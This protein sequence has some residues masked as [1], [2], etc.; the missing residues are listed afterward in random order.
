M[1]RTL[2]L[3]ALGVALIGCVPVS[4]NTL[5]SGGAIDESNESIIL[6]GVAPDNFRITLG[7]GQVNSRGNF[8]D[9]LSLT[10]YIGAYPDDGYVIG[11]SEGEKTYGVTAVARG[12]ENGA[13]A[14]R[15]Y[16][17]CGGRETVVFDVS[18]GEML[19]IGDFEYAVADN[20]MR[21]KF[22]RDF[23]AASAYFDTAF[24]QYAGRLKA[25]DISMHPVVLNCTQT[26][27][28]RQ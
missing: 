23:E 19:Y 1:I 24:P 28:I 14:R 10:G 22:E 12:E 5:P 8:S 26:I 6:V 7:P 20:R 27:Y 3:L 18:P 16:S 2:L 21:F 25:A 11:R 13:E 15:T 4:S 17:V 9:G